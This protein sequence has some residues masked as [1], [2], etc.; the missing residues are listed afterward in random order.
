MRDFFRRHDIKAASVHSGRSSDP[1]AQ[2][3]RDLKSGDL[4]IIC[5]VDVFNE[6]LD[7]PDINTVLMLRPTESPVI[8]LQQ[9][10]RVLRL[11]DAKPHLTV[12][13]FIGNHR[14]FLTKPQSLVFLLGEDLPPL[15]ALQK[16][17][18][19]T[20]DLPDGCLIDISVEAIDLLRSLVQTSSED[21]LVYEY[22]SFRDAQ[23]VWTHG[24]VARHASPSSPHADD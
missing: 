8:F 4:E 9:L 21:I 18:N 23:M 2:S 24:R 14:S 15:V 22:L 6:G 19:K 10:G 16:I 13:D 20:L 17:Q 3:L 12:I 7:V 5:A 11:A 1:R